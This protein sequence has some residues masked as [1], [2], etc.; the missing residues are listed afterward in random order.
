MN[1]STVKA[2][3]RKG[4]G[5]A[6]NHRAQPAVN[7]PR[8]PMRNDSLERTVLGTISTYK[9]QH[10]HL[11]L[12]SEALF[13]LHAHKL[14]F[15]EMKACIERGD[16]PDLATI[17]A[18]LNRLN[19]LPEVGGPKYLADLMDCITVNSV[20]P[21][22]QDL[23][24][25]RVRRETR[26]AL[27]EAIKEL[28]SPGTSV[29]P[30]VQ[31]AAT[32]LAQATGSL[33]TCT[34]SE[35]AYETGW[36]PYPVAALPEQIA[37][38]INA[39]ADSLP[40][41]PAYVVPGV[42]A[43]IAASIGGSCCLQ[44]KEGWCEMPILWQVLIA[45]PSTMK[46]PA[47]R[48]AVMPLWRMERGLQMDYD[49]EES[50][51]KSELAEW[52][53]ESGG[54]KGSEAIAHA[55]KQPQ[56]PKRPRL[57]V[58]DTTIEK[59]AV[60]MADNP[61][62]VIVL[63]DE[64]RGW[65]GAMGRYSGGSGAGAEESQ[66]LELWQGG[67]TIVDRKTGEHQ[68]LYIANAMANVVGTTQPDSFA[69]AISQ[70]QFDNG[71]MPRILPYMP[72]RRPKQ[73]SLK[74]IPE[75]T[76]DAYLTLCENI[77]NREHGFLNDKQWKP[78]SVTWT[79]GGANAW[80]DWYDA[81]GL[82]QAGSEGEHL[83]ALAKLE[84]YCARFALILCIADYHLQNSPRLAVN[85]K[86]VKR[87]IQLVEW[88]AHEVQRV[89]TMMRT[90]TDER[91]ERRLIDLI[92]DWGGDVTPRRLQQSNP[93]KYRK[94]EDA[95]RALDALVEDGKGVWSMKPSGDRGGRPS[96][97]FTLKK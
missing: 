29:L 11:D 42:L 73:R 44:I 59:L 71:F 5:Y 38:F 91:R 35:H 23:N 7:P 86:H 63:R 50:K 70:E 26:N 84:A 92:T 12:M 15:R 51:F 34:D 82:R 62:G 94:V 74:V 3:A 55:Q 80:W 32:T 60:I 13:Y 16:N 95:R 88:Y 18:G 78:H 64:L 10:V 75:K 48:K 4:N 90:P 67:E 83:A 87:A 68:T 37:D 76:L 43:S 21:L 41:D 72:P 33:L 97:V 22:I 69:R 40:C 46:S 81:W 36:Q 53:A 61:R 31:T 57:V 14:I 17:A 65:F 47:Q 2:P 66:W 93:S 25:L 52:K 6:S 79:S 20:L 27:R 19:Q 28:E 56:A 9:A 96:E 58:V 77:R 24:Q 39:A 8:D 85:E 89:Y 49:A 45:P 54:L 1:N 30:I